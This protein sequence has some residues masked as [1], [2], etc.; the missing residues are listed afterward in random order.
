[1]ANVI[2][3]KMFLI[4]LDEGKPFDIADLSLAEWREIESRAKRCLQAGQT[5]HEKVAFVAGFLNYISEKQAMGE[6][7]GDPH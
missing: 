1:M 7:F 3:R 5:K 6:P 2:E 4:E